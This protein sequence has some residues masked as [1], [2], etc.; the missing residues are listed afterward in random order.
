MSQ[1]WVPIST[2]LK[3]AP[4]LLEKPKYAKNVAMIQVDK[5]L[6]NLSQRTDEGKANRIR[7]CSIRITDVCNL[8]CHTCGQWGDHGFLRSCSLKELKGQE[9]T[10]DRYIELLRD[11]NQQGHTPSVYLW[12]GEPML[13]KGSVE[14]IEEAARLGMAPSIATNGTGLTENAERLV[15]APMFVIQI[16]I[17]GPDEATHNA[18]RPGATS[19][20]NNFATITK[21]IGRI[22]TLRTETKQRLPLIAGLTT[23]NNVNYNRL[24]D[25]YEVFKDKVDVC[26]FYLAWWIDEES[27][28][29]HA[30]DFEERFGF[31]PQKHFGW[32]GSWRPPDYGVLSEQLS[33]LNSRAASLSGPAVIIMPPLTD[34]KDLETYYSDHDCTFGFDRCVSIFSAVEINSNGDMS[35]CRDYH[36]FVVG[37]VKEKTISELWNSKLY[38]KFRKSLSE[39]GLMPVCARCCGL[40]GY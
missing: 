39:K 34:P 40:M 12:G 24:V 28:E 25:I 16:S 1:S 18:S 21:A 13:Y 2:I 19:S 27:A 22:T 5:F 36:D 32:I 35:P 26:V 37:N 15:A 10:P 38:R 29:K 9:V 14:I 11:L 23:I 17:D 20:V 30:K 31:K 7:Q 6:R 4:K 33:I 3:T 8:R